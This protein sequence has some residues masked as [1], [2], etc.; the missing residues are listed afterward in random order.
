MRVVLGRGVAVVAFFHRLALTDNGIEGQLHVESGDDPTCHTSQDFEVPRFDAASF[1]DGTMLPTG[2]MRLPIPGKLRGQLGGRA[3]LT[4]GRISG[5]G[6]GLV[7]R[8]PATLP[9]KG[10][11]MP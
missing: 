7:G 3:S 2:G 5:A 9:R 8:P 11:V 10:P 6:P 1:W 4:S